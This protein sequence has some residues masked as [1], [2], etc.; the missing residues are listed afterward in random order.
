MNM[1]SRPH[2]HAGTRVA[3]SSGVGGGV[4]SRELKR[5]VR[6]VVGV[7]VGHL[8]SQRL[9]SCEDV[10]AQLPALD[11]SFQWYYTT[12]RFCSLLACSIL[13]KR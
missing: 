2:T 3:A 9:W 11:N 5:A 1:T 13:L 4:A 7:A 10:L 8:G 12:T 6:Q